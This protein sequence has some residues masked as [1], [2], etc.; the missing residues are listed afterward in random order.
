[1]TSCGKLSL[2]GRGWRLDCMVK[3]PVDLLVLLMA[4]LQA[5][6]VDIASSMTSDTFAIVARC[7]DS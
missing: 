3:T 7:A 4:W 2:V 5:V 1:M 6:T